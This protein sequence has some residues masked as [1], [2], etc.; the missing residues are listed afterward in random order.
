MAGFDDDLVETDEIK[1][2]PAVDELP[3]EQ[4]DK[5]R[6]VTREN[7]KVEG[8]TH[9]RDDHCPCVGAVINGVSVSFWWLTTESAAAF[10]YPDSP[11]AQ[12]TILNVIKEGLESAGEDE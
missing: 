8:V 9:W 5:L 11:T 4:R 12:E 6:L 10:Y 7:L 3:R 2:F 1:E